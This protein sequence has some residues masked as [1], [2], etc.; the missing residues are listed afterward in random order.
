M[1]RNILY[2]IPENNN[3]IAVAKYERSLNSCCMKRLCFMVFKR[4]VRDLTIYDVASLM[5]LPQD[6]KAHAQCE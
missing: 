4:S 2:L 1:E 5:T 6:V 3:L